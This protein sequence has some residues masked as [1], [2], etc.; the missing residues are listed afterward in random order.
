MTHKHNSGVQAR[1]TQSRVT[2]SPRKGWIQA[3]RTR[4]LF[5]RQHQGTEGRGGEGQEGHSGALGWAPGMNPAGQFRTPGGRTEEH[6]SPVRRTTG[7]LHQTSQHGGL[8]GAPSFL[9][10]RL[11]LRGQVA[12]VPEAGGAAAGSAGGAQRFAGSTSGLERGA[13]GLWKGHQ[14]GQLCLCCNALILMTP[15][16]CFIIK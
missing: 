1:G 6:A 9:H 13:E 8:S 10:F 16:V 3:F 12:R 5:G 11:S 15:V 7:R 14:H 2:D 4:G